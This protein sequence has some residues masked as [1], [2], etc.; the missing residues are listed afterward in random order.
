MSSC[1]Q[2]SACNGTHVLG[3]IQNGLFERRENRR[4]VDALEQLIISVNG[5]YL[6]EWALGNG[7]YSNLE[8]A[9]MLDEDKVDRPKLKQKAPFYPGTFSQAEHAFKCISR[10]F[11]FDGCE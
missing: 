10:R 5:V 1:Y 7:C 11:E 6:F 3:V 4:L 2:S 8:L 9:R